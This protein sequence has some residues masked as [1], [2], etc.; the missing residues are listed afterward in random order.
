MKLYD[1]EGNLTSVDRS[2]T[3]NGAADAVGTIKESWTYD[4][5]HRPVTHSR[6]AGAN[7]ST[8]TQ[9]YDAAGNLTSV[10]TRRGPTITMTY[11]P[12][13]LLAT[14]SIPGVTY[15]DTLAGIGADDG[16][17]TRDCPQR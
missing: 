1:F 4:L 12:T 16:Q 11:G 6:Y 5:A 17:H 13:N 10:L 8:E 7:L 15:A 2:G 14:R 9:G 3:T